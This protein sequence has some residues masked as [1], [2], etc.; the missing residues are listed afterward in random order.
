M[1]MG[2]KR[3]KDKGLPPRMYKRGEVYYHACWI[4][5]KLKW[6]RL[7]AN[8]AEALTLWAAIEGQS[9]VPG[10]KTGT[11]GAAIARYEGEILPALRP[12]TQEDYHRILKALRDVFGHMRIES[13]RRPDVAGYLDRRS[14][15]VAANREIAVLSSVFAY[16]IRWGWAEENP[17][18]G[19]RRNKE[20]PRKRYITDA[21]MEKLRQCADEQWKC[22]IDLAYLTSMRRGDIMKLRL[23]QCTEEGLLVAQEKTG[24]RVLYTWTPALRAVVSKARGLRRRIGSLSL[25]AS[26]D[27]TPYTVSG[28]N[29]AWRRLLAK[30]EVDDCHF[31]DIRA[32]SLTDASKIG[33]RDY[34]QA[35]A[36]HADGSMTEV[37]IR[38]RE[39]TH[40]RP[41]H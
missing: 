35:L 33:G 39:F 2:R 4:D 1:G 14:A 16:S 10:E 12:R 41:L 3:T 31:H 29:S 21:E 19:V 6:T 25:F 5:R 9:T 15:K 27:G 11:I 22:I 23:D 8:K 26:Q 36:G 18:L 20:K 17:C 32:K 40:V 34:A 13:L 24:A 38:D 7:S 37:Y 30:S 28:W